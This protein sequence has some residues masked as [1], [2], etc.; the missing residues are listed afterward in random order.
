MVKLV[1]NNYGKS[2][3]RLVRVVRSGGRHELKD[4]SVDIQLTGDFEAAHTRGDNREVLPTDT[5]KN[6]VYVLAKQQPIVHIEGF[7]IRLVDPFLANLPQVSEAR[8][9]ISE[10]MWGRIAVDGDPHPWAFVAGARERRTARVIATRSGHSVEAG[11]DDLLVLKS[12]ESAFSGFLRDSYTTLKDTRDRILA[13]VLTASWSY[14]GGAD[15][16]RCWTGIRG[17]LLATFAGHKSESVQHTLY[18][19]GEAVL[20]TFN[21]VREIRLS[22]P[23]KHHLLVDLKPFGMENEN[24]VFVPTDEPY[25]L[26]EATLRR[27]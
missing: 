5:M 27:D 25:G 20:G 8:V 15:Y 13:T 16:D 4:V 19:M 12:G 6:M 17:L 11:I 3:V 2:R 23:N 1:S 10:K 21:E 18:A 24:E 26:I 9:A 14:A 7:G 22:M